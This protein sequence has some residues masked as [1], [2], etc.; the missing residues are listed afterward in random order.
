[1]TKLIY[2]DTETTGLS[3][4]SNGI[5]QLAYIIEIDGKV[6]KRGQFK[7]NPFSYKR[8]RRVTEKALEVNGYKVEDFK[9][10]M[11]ASDAAYE[12]YAVMEKYIDRWDNKDKFIFVGYNSSFDTGFVQ[13]L[14]KES[15]RGE[16]H[17]FIS[18]KDL[19]VFALVKYLSYVGKFDTGPSQSLVS[20]CKAIGLELD[21]HDAVA[22]IEATR[23][24]HLHLVKE[25]L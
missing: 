11:E 17:Q 13:E 10:F 8:P 12:F 23:D 25:Y 5:I 1:M 16:Y 3:K 7:V 15:A 2:I 4:I 21:A 14:M 24:L 19:D 22:D 9:G 18:Y 6:V 20:A